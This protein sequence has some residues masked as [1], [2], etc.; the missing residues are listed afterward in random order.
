[1][2]F[3]RGRKAITALRY[4][5]EAADA[6]L[7]HFSPLEC[8]TLTERALPLLD[9]APDGS[10]RNT[11]EITLQTLH[12]LAAA[13]AIGSGSEAKSAFQRAYALLDEVPHHPMR[14]RLLH[15]FGFMLCLRAEYAEALVVAERAETLGSA[16]ND[17]VLLSTAYTVH[18][19]IDQLQGRWGASRT[20]LERGLTLAERV[21]VGPGEFFVD[22]QVMLLG[23]LSVPLVNLG[24]VA[25]A[26]ACLQRAHARARD[27]G[28]PMARLL[29]I[30]HSAL[31]EVRLGNA[32]SV[33]ALGDEM[34]AL[35]D[36]FAL[37]HGRTACRWFRAW[38]DARMGTS[39]DSHLR[40]R[41]AYEENL[42]LGM[43]AGSSEVLG[44]AAEAL[45]LAGDL[46]GAQR[47]LEEALRVASEH[48][49]RV[50]LPQLFLIEAALARARGEPDAAA[51]SSRRAIAE[52]RSQGPWLELLALVDLCAHGG[53]TGKD[54]AA[55][56]A[57]IDSLPEASGTAAVA[58]ARELL[59][60]P[61]PRRA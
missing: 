7:A 50:Y 13:R 19:E 5:A 39:H 55:L 22:P 27:R 17:P 12:G 18:G 6:A 14:G 4:Y 40:I 25:Q 1:M 41:E 44:Y 26:R 53:A 23:L 59:E 35:V 46:D 33:G 60:G 15:A 51:K 8:M 34:Q 61:K 49:E 9:Q 54:R 52:A 31:V 38:A 20:W 37:A 3:E 48:E 16:A 56:A 47:E 30:W 11:L 43:V 58:K 29:A 32:E 21:D 28:W 2:H 42:R 45:L 24:L 10:D 57:L 36:E